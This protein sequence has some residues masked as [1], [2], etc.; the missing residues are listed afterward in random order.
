[1]LCALN[2]ETVGDH[3]T[4]FGQVRWVYK[5]I[6]ESHP[7]VQ[8]VIKRLWQLQPSQLIATIS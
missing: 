7:A 4:G 5:P 8:L 6:G 2:L 3:A 1:M